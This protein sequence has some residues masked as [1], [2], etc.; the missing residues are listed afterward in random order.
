MLIL[1]DATSGSRKMS[2]SPDTALR[3]PFFF[4]ASL[5]E[6][7]KAYAAVTGVQTTAQDLLRIGERI[8]YH[9]RIMNALNGFTGEHDD[10]PERFFREAGSS[11]NGIAI[12]PLN[13]DEFLRTRAGYYTVRG[14]DKHGMPTKEKAEEL[15]L[16]WEQGPPERKT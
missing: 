1:P 4:A 7:A 3:T 2:T 6:Y 14:L 15:G 5:E 10:L 13:R 8:Y 12:G 16:E 9:E 11:G